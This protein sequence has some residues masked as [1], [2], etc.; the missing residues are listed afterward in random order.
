MLFRHSMHFIFSYFL[1]VGSS[2]C[3]GS[4]LA[5]IS[6]ISRNAE[7]GR[8]ATPV[9]APNLSESYRLTQDK[10]NKDYYNSQIRGADAIKKNGEINPRDPLYSV[11]IR[12]LMP[13]AVTLP[14]PGD[15]KV[16]VYKVGAQKK[17]YLVW[18]YRE[19][20]FGSKETSEAGMSLGLLM[21]P[22]VA[23]RP[24]AFS[25]EPLKALEL[26]EDETFDAFLPI[27]FYLGALGEAWGVRTLQH[28]CGA[29]GS[30][31]ATTYR[32][33]FLE[34]GGQLTLIFNQA[35]SYYGNYGGDWK[36]DGTR[37]HII[38]EMTGTLSA[39]KERVDAIPVL[40][41]KAKVKGK[42]LQRQFKPVKDSIGRYTY[43]TTD[44]EI[45]ELVD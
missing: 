41:L 42:I 18:A 27:P 25:S 10:N 11:I 1:L 7:S 35:V 8:E 29:G 17:Q 21:S 16:G 4:A 28:G 39:G 33:L 34:Q 9:I 32:R 36:K 45:I 44:P 23:D 14:S 22:P 30:I 3:C 15:L 38:E 26:R 6:P 37:Q 31:C 19:A 20:Q 5:Q 24:L 40:V 43:V 12:A 13:N 2:V